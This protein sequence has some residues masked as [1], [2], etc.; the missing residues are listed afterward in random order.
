MDEKIEALINWVIVKVKIAKI[1]NIK[2]TTG[3]KL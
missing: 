1:C 3:G 2:L